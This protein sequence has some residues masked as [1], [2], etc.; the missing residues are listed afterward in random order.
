MTVSGSNSVQLKFMV[1]LFQRFPIELF[2]VILTIYSNY[3]N[4]NYILLDNKLYVYLNASKGFL[5]FS[6]SWKIQDIL[7]SIQYW[8]YWKL[9]LL[10]LVILRFSV[11]MG[12]AIL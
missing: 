12:Q 3:S 7:T 1:T 5:Y 4:K 6:L 10:Q 8:Q 9:I 2:Q 11:V